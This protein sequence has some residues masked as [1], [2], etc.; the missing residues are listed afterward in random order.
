MIKFWELPDSGGFSSNGQEFE[1]KFALT[2]TSDRLEALAHIV[3][4]TEPE[5]DS[6]P[7]V[8]MSAEPVDGFNELWTVT[9]EYAV[10]GGSTGNLPESDIGEERMRFSTKGGT[11]RIFQAANHIADYANTDIGV[12]PPNHEGA[13]NVTT[14]GIEG[15]EIDDTGFGF[16]ITK[17]VAFVDFT[18]VYTQMLYYA[19]NKVNSSSWRDYEPGELR[20]V[21]ISADQRDAESFSVVFEFLAIPNVVDQ[22]I[23]DITGIAKLGHELA[24]AEHAKLV[25]ETTDPPT[26]RQ[27]IKAVHIEET[28]GYFDFNALGLAP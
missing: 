18:R 1:L 2:G 16:Q 3:M 19:T 8:D 4:N 11:K 22:T 20:I 7:R 6:I 23:G 26:I 17:I 12:D 21:D 27:K 14:E 24:W 15:I 28:Y 10:G 25:D 13:I 5:I 9:I